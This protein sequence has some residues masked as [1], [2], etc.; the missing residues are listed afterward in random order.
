[1]NLFNWLSNCPINFKPVFYTRYL[2]DIFI[3]F[4]HPSHAPLFLQYM[5]NQHPN[6]KFTMENEHNRKMSFLD[7]LVDRRNNKFN[8]SV[9]RKPTFSGQGLSFFSHCSFKFKINCIKALLHRAYNICSTYM[10]LDREFNFLKQYFYNNGYS[11]DIVER[12]IIVNSL[13][14]NLIL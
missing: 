10:S 11:K 6:I 14:L 8:T 12:S 9:Y 3:L 13:I 5:N 7:V 1:M 4:H 2:D